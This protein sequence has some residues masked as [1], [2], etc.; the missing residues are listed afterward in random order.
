MK[1]MGGKSR[2]AKPIG[3]FLKSLRKPGQ[4]Y[5]EPFVGAAS[6]MC[7]MAAGGPAEAFDVHPD[8]ILMW[9]ALQTGWVP[10]ARVSPAEHC[11]LR[12]ARPSARRSFVGF[13]CSFGGKFFGG[14]ARS[15]NCPR[16][17]AREGRSS[18]AKKIERLRTV[19]FMCA[20]Y[21]TLRP[22]GALIYCDPPY[23]G[24]A[25]F[26]GTPKFNHD[27]FWEIMRQWSRNN[28]VVVSECSAPPDF[29]AVLGI[30]VP[31]TMRKG[32]PPR[33]EFLFQADSAAVSC[34]SEKSGSSSAPARPRDSF[35]VSC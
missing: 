14:Y 21:Q 10:P 1:Y 9:Q 30:R 12:H 25:G 32:L 33:R 11:R 23:K 4:L 26:S 27:R 6:V 19:K 17:Y 3:A 29:V 5:I 16:G 34:T 31:A 8:L 20:D 24:T 35:T 18:L 22:A 15:K 13:A 28:T 7:E 2:I